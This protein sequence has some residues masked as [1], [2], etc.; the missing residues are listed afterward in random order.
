MPIVRPRHSCGP[1]PKLRY[2]V[3]GRSSFTVFLQNCQRLWDRE[4]KNLRLRKYFRIPTSMELENSLRLACITSSSFEGT[5]KASEQAIS[6]L[7]HP[8]GA[9]LVN[10]HLD[11]SAGI[12]ISGQPQRAAKT[13]RFE[14]VFFEYFVSFRCV[15]G[16]KCD[17]LSPVALVIWAEI[18]IDE[19]TKL[20][21][22]SIKYKNKYYAGNVYTTV[23]TVP[24]TPT[25][26]PNRISTVS[27]I[28][29]PALTNCLVKLAPNV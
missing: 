13:R 6:F 7:Q 26:L 2:A 17:Y 21:R 3:S 27:L 18:E 19:L 12:Y 14:D 10:H 4:A 9:L 23:P 15:L 29:V 1:R 28:S 25:E 5:H 8:F 22:V 24:I 11:R 20:H 16:G